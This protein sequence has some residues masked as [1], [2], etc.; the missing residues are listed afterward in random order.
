ML[1]LECQ[2]RSS[3]L[4]A[5]ARALERAGFRVERPVDHHGPVLTAARDVHAGGTVL[6]EWADAVDAAD[7]HLRDAGVRGRVH[8]L[9]VQQRRPVSR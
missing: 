5:A 3:D 6:G 9:G 2:V 7:A 8:L 1:L 4:A